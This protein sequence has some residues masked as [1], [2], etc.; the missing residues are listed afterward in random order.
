MS[1]I[2]DSGF[3]FRCPFREEALGLFSFMH[4]FGK[5]WSTSINEYFAPSEVIYGVDF[6]QFA[7]SHTNQY[8]RRAKIVDASEFPIS[9]LHANFVISE[10]AAK[11]SC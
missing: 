5:P 3:F 11:R 6:W 7:L 4:I 10:W 8:Y 2:K 9:D 1:D